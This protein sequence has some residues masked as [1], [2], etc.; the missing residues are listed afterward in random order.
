[1]EADTCGFGAVLPSD[2]GGRE[3]SGNGDLYALDVLNAL[4]FPGTCAT[5]TV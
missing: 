5:S 2:I 3:G 4:F 1:M